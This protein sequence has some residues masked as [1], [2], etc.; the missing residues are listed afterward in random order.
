MIGGNRVTEEPTVRRRQLGRE[1]RKARLAAGLTQSVVAQE[2]ICT[3]GKINKIETTL[4]AIS[5]DELETMVVLYGLSPEKADEVRALAAQDHADGPQRTGYSPA[6]SAFGELS[7]LEPDAEEILCWHSERVP[8]PLQS[9]QYM[10]QQ[11]HPDTTTTP[12]VVRLLLQRRARA[13]IFSIEEPPVYHVVLSESSLLRMPG[14]RTPTLVIDQSEHLLNMVSQYSR[15]TL[16]ILPFDAPVRFVSSDFKILR[17]AGEQE[18]FAYIEHPGGARTFKNV[19][20]LARF[21]EHWE[22]LRDAALSTSDSRSF[23]EELV[24]ES[25][26]KWRAGDK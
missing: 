20:D 24:K 26:A 12:G 8:G 13:Q 18:D 25:R 19:K 23:L 10:L 5:L 17:F 15:L 11:H 22:Q 2:L 7:D 21:T 3:Q 6:W 14:G 1:L 9:E 16:Q 4:V